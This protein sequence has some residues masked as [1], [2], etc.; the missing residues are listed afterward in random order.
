MPTS[1]R[2]LD[3]Y[4]T[5]PIEWERVRD[6]MAGEI[7]QA[8]GTGGPGRHTSWLTTINPDGTPHV[9][10]LGVVKRDGIWYFNSG[11]GTRKSRNIAADPRCV[12]SV[13]THPFDLV[14]E[15]SAQRVADAAELGAVA[16]TFVGQGWPAKV[17]GDG[18]TAEYSAPSAGPPPWHVYRIEPTRVY[19]FGTAEPY[20]ATRFDLT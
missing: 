13:A 7:T 16:A 18:L 10:P 8:P 1:Q 3:G 14:V 4:G 15:G 6:T 2:N 19:A 9:T 17:E 11:P 20:G 5:P 12:I